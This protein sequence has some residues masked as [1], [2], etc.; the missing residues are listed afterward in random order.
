MENEGYYIIQALIHEDWKGSIFGVEGVEMFKE[1]NKVLVE[2]ED[3]NEDWVEGVIIEVDGSTMPYHV[4]YVDFKG[5]LITNWFERSEVKAREGKTWC[6]ETLNSDNRTWTRAKGHSS[7]AIAR[8]EI[9]SSINHSCTKRVVEVTENVK[10]L[11]TYIL[12]VT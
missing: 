2:S 12:T 11:S 8:Q 5:D 9:T 1:G 7:E 10:V 6:V 3:G 4:S